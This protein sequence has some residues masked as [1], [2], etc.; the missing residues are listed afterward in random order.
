MRKPPIGLDGVAGNETVGAI[1]DFQYQSFGPSKVDGR[2]DPNYGTLRRL[3]EIHNEPALVSPKTYVR[4]YRDMY[5]VEVGIDGR[6]FVQPG[7]WVSRYSAAIYGDYW[8]IQE[9]GRMENGQMTRLANPDMI[10]AGEVIYHLPTWQAFMNGKTKV[11]PPPAPPLPDEMKK[12]LTEEAI[13][14]DFRLPGDHGIGFLN[15][16]GQ[17]LAFAQPFVEVASWAAKM[18]GRVAGPLE[19]ILIPFDIYGNLVSWVNAGDAGERQYAMRAAAYATTAWAF[20][21]AIPS[22]SARH[23]KMFVDSGV[24]EARLRFLRQA[25]AKSAE[26]ARNSQ[27]RYAWENLPGKSHTEREKGW[28]AV[29]R[30]TGDGKKT[31]LCRRLLESIGK[32]VLQD[33]W[34]TEKRTWE[35]NLDIPYPE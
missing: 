25:W 2:V 17:I 13:Q 3:V 23:Y 20:E 8:H 34:S 5:K 14:H 4:G 28:K 7:D 12:R 35:A 30:A 11:Q 31:V 22:Q 33:G 19:I 21:E 18:V 6:I 16:L 1:R 9:F 27:I 26:A 10:R 29:V 32:K 15:K 24:N